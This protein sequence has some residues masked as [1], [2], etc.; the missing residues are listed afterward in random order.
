MDDT[1]SQENK[2]VLMTIQNR[3]NPEQVIQMV[4]SPVNAHFE[5]EGL[6]RHFGLSEIGVETGDLLESIQEYGEV[7]SYLLETMSAAKELKLPY[8]YQ[9]EFEFKG[10]RYSMREKG[11]VRLLKRMG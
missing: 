11:D 9:N 5:T 1:I 10:A 3:K 7:I 8:F 4:M 6:R 2:T